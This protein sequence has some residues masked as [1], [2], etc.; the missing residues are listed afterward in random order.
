V[1]TLSDQ[2]AYLTV[3]VEEL[4]SSFFDYTFMSFTQ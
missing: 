3:N 2:K 1:Y 4:Q